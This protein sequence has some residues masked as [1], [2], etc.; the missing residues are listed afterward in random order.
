MDFNCVGQLKY[1]FKNKVKISRQSLNESC[2]V[3]SH[4]RVDIKNVENGARMRKLWFLEVGKWICEICCE[5]DDVARSWPSL[6]DHGSLRMAET[7]PLGRPAFSLRAACEVGTPRVLQPPTV[8]LEPRRTLRR[9]PP[10]DLIRATTPSVGPRYAQ[11]TEASQAIKR[12]RGQ[13]FFLHL[14]TFFLS[15]V[16]LSSSS[17]PP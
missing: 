10:A 1:N 2:R 3:R 12:Q 11:R 15:L 14:S 9:L 6:V 13:P 16:S 17:K 7:S 4:L 8:Q 5:G